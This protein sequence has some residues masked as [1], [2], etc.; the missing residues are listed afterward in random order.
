MPGTA[1][2]SA[3]MASVM[4]FL[5]SKPPVFV[6]R[7]ERRIEVCWGVLGGDA[8]LPPKQEAVDDG[9]ES[10]AAACVRASSSVP[11]GH[12]TGAEKGGH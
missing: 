8:T 10:R 11:K 7:M 3:T 5:Y 9:R 6:L 2:M 1:A 4:A 12:A